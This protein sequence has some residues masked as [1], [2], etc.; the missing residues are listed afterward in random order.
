MSLSPDFGWRRDGIA[1]R[2]NRANVTP[3]QLRQLPRVVTPA[4]KCGA[5]VRVWGRTRHGADNAG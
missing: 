5:D 2:S 1:V 3:A 4:V